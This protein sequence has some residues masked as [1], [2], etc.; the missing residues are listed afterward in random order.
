MAKAKSIYSCTECGATAPKWQGQC[1]GCGAWNTLV[2]TL[3]RAIQHAH[4]HSI[5]H[6]DLAVRNFL[7]T[8]EGG[9]KVADFGVLERCG[10]SLSRKR[11]RPVAQYD[12]GIVVNEKENAGGVHEILNERKIAFA[13]LHRKAS[14]VFIQ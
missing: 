2:E 7:L 10:C 9:L 14:R 11:W 5:V 12:P 8:S 1:P 4:E 6:R 13:V 3:A